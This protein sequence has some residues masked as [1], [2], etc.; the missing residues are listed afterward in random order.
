MLTKKPAYLAGFFLSL[1][2]RL[3]GG[4]VLSIRLST[5]FIRLFDSDSD[6]SLVIGTGY[7]AHFFAVP[8]DRYLP[9]LL[10]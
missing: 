1:G 8:G 3:G 4:G 2:W 6:V 10:G 7:L 9:T 5:S